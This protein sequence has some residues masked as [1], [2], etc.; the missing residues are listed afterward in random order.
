MAHYRTV[1]L[2]GERPEGFLESGHFWL[3]EFLP[4]GVFTVWMDTSGLLTVAGPEGAIDPEQAWPYHRAVEAVRDEFDRD[5]FRS[6]VSDVSAYEFSLLAP[7]GLG[8]AY[9][10]TAMPSVFGLDIW[11]GT[12]DSF[13]PV[14]VAERVFEAVGLATVPTLER[15]V[16]ARN[17][18][19][20]GVSM[21]TAT[22]AAKPVA[23]VLMQKKQGNAVVALR[24]GFTDLKRAPPSPAGSPA[25]LQEWITETV[26]TDLLRRYFPKVDQP[27]VA[28]PLETLDEV[29][30]AELA[31]RAFQSVGRPAM[32]RPDRFEQVVH[33]RLVTI[34]N[35]ERS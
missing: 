18:S 27:L 19:S 6:A 5:A 23:G 13:A 28:S 31:R 33:D 15:E 1:H 12:T 17:L 8:L 34:R 21:P 16:P 4:G 32:E 14:D 20:T 7:L 11:D 29:V 35:Q 30:A 25:D 2:L 10:W 3:K 9:E 24:D 26:D 22:H